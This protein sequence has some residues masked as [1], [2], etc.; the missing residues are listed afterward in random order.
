M[1]KSIRTIVSAFVIAVIS[2]SL[3]SCSNETI[4]TQDK[5]SKK[6]DVNITFSDFN[7]T[8]DDGNTSTRASDQT[9]TSAG[10]NRISLSVFDSNNTLAFSTTKNATTDGDDFENISCSLYPGNYQFVVVVHKANEDSEEAVAIASPTQATLTTSKLFDVF[11]VNKTV[12]IVADQTN[13]VSIDLGKCI[14]SKFQLYTNDPT[15]SSVATCEIILNPSSSATTA[16][17]FNPTTGFAPENYMHRTD[18]TRDEELTTFQNVLLGVY[19]F[20]TQNPQNISV[21]VNMK[22]AS[23][24]IVKSRTFD[25]VPMAPQRITRAKGSFFNS[26]AT[27]S[28]VL[29]SNYDTRYDYVF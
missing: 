8:F 19:C 4:D 2:S 1:N 24:N 26:T 17:V 14:T 10:M 25:D 16:Y 5:S 23:G 13:N 29:D 3:H 7:F 20:L 21:T 22:D 11:S 9:P 6:V 15:P 28:F 18:F 27:F 12:D